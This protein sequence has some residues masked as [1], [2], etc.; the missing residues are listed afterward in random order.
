MGGV[1]GI[2]F[3][4]KVWIVVHCNWVHHRYGFGRFGICNHVMIAVIVS[5]ANRFLS[6][7]MLMAIGG[8]AQAPAP[9]LSVLATMVF[10]GMLNGTG[11]DRRRRLLSIRPWSADW[12]GQVVELEPLGNGETSGDE[13]Y[14]QRSSQERTRNQ[15]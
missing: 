9:K 8:I 10:I 4:H 15:V 1:L 6:S 14:E 5:A 3:K 7:P 11:T 2:Y 12:K 13:E